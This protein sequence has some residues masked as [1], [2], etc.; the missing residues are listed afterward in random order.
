MGLSRS[1]RGTYRDLHTESDHHQWRRDDS[2]CDSF[3]FD[4]YRY[5]YTDS[6]EICRDDACYE[7]RIVPGMP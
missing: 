3:Q 5:S 4:G 7:W 1:Q 6:L 2:E